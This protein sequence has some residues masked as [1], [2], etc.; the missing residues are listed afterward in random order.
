MELAPNQAAHKESAMT[1]GE[2]LRAAKKKSSRLRLFLEKSIPAPASKT[3]YPPSA[4]SKP[5]FITPVV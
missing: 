2:R 3:K 4:I 1:P 5:V